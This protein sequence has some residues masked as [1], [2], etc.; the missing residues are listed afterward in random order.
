MQSKIESLKKIFAYSKDGNDLT[1]AIKVKARAK[2]NA[3]KGVVLIN[4]IWYLKLT[5]KGVFTIDSLAY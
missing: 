4:Y 1:F 3:I 5:I 2:V